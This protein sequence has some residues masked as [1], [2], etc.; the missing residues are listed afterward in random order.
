MTLLLQTT[1][2]ISHRTHHSAYAAIDWRIFIFVLERTR[3]DDHG[4]NEA[5]SNSTR[6]TEAKLNA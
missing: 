3:F 6:D 1:E 4:R 2:H 5:I